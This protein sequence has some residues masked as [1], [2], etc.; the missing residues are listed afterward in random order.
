MEIPNNAYKILNENLT[1]CSTLSQEYSKL[2]GRN[3]KK[4][5]RQLCI[6]I[7]I[8]YRCNTSMVVCWLIHCIKTF[9]G[10][11]SIILSHAWKGT[12]VQPRLQSFSVV[13]L[14]SWSHWSKGELAYRPPS[15]KAKVT[16]LTYSCT[17]YI[18]IR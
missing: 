9:I 16:A 11:A 7:E 18:S 17:L 10:E 13:G 1:G 14:K 3:W 6:T 4:L 8:V 5:G 2:I 12:C 15:I